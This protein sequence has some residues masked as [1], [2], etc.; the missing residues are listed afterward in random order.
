MTI[1]SVGSEDGVEQLLDNGEMMLIPSIRNSVEKFVA[2]SPK[3]R[4]GVTA[5]EEKMKDRPLT[6]VRSIPLRKNPSV[7]LL[8]ALVTSR[9]TSKAVLLVREARSLG[10]RNRQ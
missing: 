5:R 8:L 7:L 4:S 1:A 6:P 9:E 2:K 3:A 10:S